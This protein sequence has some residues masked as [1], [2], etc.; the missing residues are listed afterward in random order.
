MTSEERNRRM[1]YGHEVPR[2]WIPEF[3]ATH[4]N[5]TNTPRGN[6]SGSGATESART[7]SEI[8]KLK[9][10]IRTASLQRQQASANQVI[11]WMQQIT[12][13]LVVAI[14]FLA[15]GYLGLAIGAVAGLGLISLR[16][17]LYNNSQ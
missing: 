5:P 11:R 14:G 2:S 8:Y 7:H 6:R 3:N 12:A 16:V 4:P 17:K 10:R 1:K 9:R 13:A 15:G